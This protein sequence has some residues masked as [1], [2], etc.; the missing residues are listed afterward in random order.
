MARTPR[1]KAGGIG[2]AEA[3]TRELVS[4]SPVERPIVSPALV[5]R[6][7]QLATLDRALEAA[8]AGASGSA[9]WCS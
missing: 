5:G 7:R 3:D 9:F 2:V 4:E 1:P 8:S 6:E